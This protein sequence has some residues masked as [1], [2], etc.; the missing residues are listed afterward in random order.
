[1]SLFVPIISSFSLSQSGPS[2][3]RR[4]EEEE[5]TKNTLFVQY[6]CIEYIKQALKTI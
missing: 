4:A 3:R 5:N 2:L 1:M 6:K